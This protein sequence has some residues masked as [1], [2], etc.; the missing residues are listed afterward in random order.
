PTTA[1]RSDLRGTKTAPS[2]A[3]VSALGDA[4]VQ[5]AS[6]VSAASAGTTARRRVAREAF[7][8]CLC[9]QAIRK[10]TTKITCDPHFKLLWRRAAASFDLRCCGG[11]APYVEQRL[12]GRHF[13]VDVDAGASL[14]RATRTAQPFASVDEMQR[15]HKELLRAV[16]PFG[17]YGLLLDVRLGP[18]RSDPEY[19]QGLASLRRQITERFARVAILV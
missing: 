16:A 18:A 10:C 1:M 17:E 5:A 14:V 2:D 8:S 7:I 6:A 9:A 11:Y 4:G 15:A 3:S 13:R 12:R 19:E